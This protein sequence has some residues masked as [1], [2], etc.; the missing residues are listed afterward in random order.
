M[1]VPALAIGLVLG[2]VWAGFA[3]DGPAATTTTLA[4]SSPGAFTTRPPVFTATVETESSAPATG[5]VEFV[6]DGLSLGHAP[7]FTRDGHRIAVMGGATLGVGAH[8]ITARFGGSD[9]HLPS[10][11][12]PL[13]QMVSEGRYFTFDAGQ[14]GPGPAPLNSTAIAVNANGSIAGSYS[15][16]DARGR[17]AGSIG[18]FKPSYASPSSFGLGGAWTV[19]SAMNDKDQVVGWSTVT[20]GAPH[21]FL[22]RFQTVDLGTLGG[23]TSQAVAINKAGQVVGT[24]STTSG[25]THGFLYSAGTLADLGTLGGAGSAALAIDSSGFAAGY[26]DL[27]SGERH[28]AYHTSS[29][30]DLGT[31][32]GTR[33]SAFA[34]NDAGQIAGTSLL[35]GDR[36]AHAFLWQ[37]GRLTDLAGPAGPPTHA[38]AMNDAG[39]VVGWTMAPGAGSLTLDAPAPHNAFLYSGGLNVLGTLHGGTSQALDIN[40]A[41]AVVGVSDG[42]AFVSSGGALRDLGTLGGPTSAARAINDAGVIVG[43]ADLASG[44]RHAVAWTPAPVWDVSVAAARGVVGRT[45]F[46]TATLKVYGLGVSPARIDFELGGVWVGSAITNENGTAVLT[47]VS[48]AGFAIGSYPGAVRATYYPSFALGVADL[49]VTVDHPPVAAD[50]S[51][52]ITGPVSVPGPGILANDTDA[53]GDA[54]TAV[55]ESGPARGTLTLAANGAFRYTPDPGPGPGVQGDAFTYRAVAAGASS[56]VVTVR[57]LGLIRPVFGGVVSAAPVTIDDS[58]WNKSQPRVSGDL[59]AYDRHIVLRAEVHYY[60]F[61][62]G[63]NAVVPHPS[64]EAENMPEL[65]RGRIVFKANQ[66]S[67]KVADVASGQSAAIAPGASAFLGGATIGGDTVA[68]TDTSGTFPGGFYAWDLATSTSTRLGDFDYPAGSI[69]PR[70]SP[71]GDRVA[72]V[73]CH[74]PDAL[75]VVCA[76]LLEARRAGGDWTTSIIADTPGFQYWSVDTDGDWI[77]YAAAPGSVLGPTRV[78]LRPE[79]TGSG[80]RVFDLPGA[81]GRPSIDRGVI[82]FDGGTDVSRDIFVYVIATNTLYQV[83]DTPGYEGSSDVSVLPSGDIRVTWLGGDSGY[84]V[85]AVTFT[86]GH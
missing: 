1:R 82:S 31:L 32:G 63:Q 9:S 76:E 33:S 46:L 19:P 69:V 15:V 54:L 14:P 77:V 50:D 68:Y 27:P 41:G 30:R 55:L 24:S 71:G 4:T 52:E 39:Q 66:G 21:A 45:T 74:S 38:V 3:D 58:P 23:G 25:A 75:S 10:E 6:A 53:D 84:V 49:V 72:W 16:L 65:D 67:Y 17:L 43:A 13:S 48:L 26:A 34:L 20:G 8:T 22:H 57:L 85:R 36:D 78:Y 56:N 59:L 37:D 5:T 73:S 81:L 28:A 86:P 64:G 18:F 79:A 44:L 42:R 40:N 11:S 2:S 51:Y 70:V 80:D 7:V 60:D 29:W 35:A 61:A 83:T 47:G 62:S 12:E